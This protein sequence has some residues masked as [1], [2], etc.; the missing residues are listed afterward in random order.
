MQVRNQYGRRFFRYRRC[1]GFSFNDPG[2]FDNVNQNWHRT[3]GFDRTEVAREIVG[4]Q[5]DFVA[6]LHPDAAQCQLNRHRATTTQQRVC[7]IKHILQLDL[8]RIC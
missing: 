5:D 4:S 8:Q 3:N 6:M 2:V 1:Q 7:T